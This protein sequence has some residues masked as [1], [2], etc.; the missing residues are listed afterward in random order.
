[1][2]GG[3]GRAAAPPSVTGADGEGEGPNLR[4]RSRGRKEGKGCAG[5]QG[6][7]REPREPEAL[8]GEGWRREDNRGTREK[9]GWRLSVLMGACIDGVKG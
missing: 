9:R 8:R 2:G 7:R 3:E 1:M 6:G 5:G 4:G